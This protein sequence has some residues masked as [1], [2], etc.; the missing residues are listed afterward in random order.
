MEFLQDTT[1]PWST[2]FQM[3]V[4]DSCGS[5]VLKEHANLMYWPLLFSLLACG[6]TSIDKNCCLCCLRLN[7]VSLAV[8]VF[9]VCHLRR[10]LLRRSPT[11]VSFLGCCLH[12]IQ[13][14]CKS[15]LSKMHMLLFSINI[16][17]HKFIWR[18]LKNFGRALCCLIVDV[19]FMKSSNCTK[20]DWEFVFKML[21]TSW[22][23]LFA[24]VSV[25][26]IKTLN[27]SCFT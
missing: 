14:F 5:L 18:L 26:R 10:L 15:A 16:C 25:V 2:Y 22:K 19:G 21:S 1:C 13:F 9:R 12:A 3:P 17:D 23:G 4:S 8:P 27:M 24:G 11:C 7:I 6:A 20:S